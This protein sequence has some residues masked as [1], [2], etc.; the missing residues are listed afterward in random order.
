MNQKT[1]LI[2]YIIVGLAIVIQFIPAN[3]PENK[4]PTDFDIMIAESIP[5]DISVILRQ[6]CYDCHSNQ[7]IYPWYSYVAP[8]SWL[9]ARDVRVGVPELNFSE[10]GALTKRQK[11][12]LLDKIAD[13]ISAGSMPFPIY[14]ITHPEAR[15][16]D[17]QR[18]SIVKW[19][20][21]LTEKVFEE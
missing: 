13:E 7:V 19:T 12:K 17:E 5:D 2:I 14:K 3:L 10:W 11:L 21:Y 18:A 8:V 16:T 20:E 15:L 9:V 6:A 4:P 1:K